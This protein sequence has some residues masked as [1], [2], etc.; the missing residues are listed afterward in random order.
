MRQDLATVVSGTGQIKPKTYVN[1]GA[2]RHGPHHPPLC[3]GGRPGEE[4]PTRCHDRKRGQQAA[5]VAGQEAAI[6][7]PRRT[8]PPTSL[9]KKPP[10][11]MWNTLRPTWSKRSSIGI[12]RRASLQGRHHGQAGLR[13][14]EGRL[15]HRCGF[16]GSGCRR[17]EPGQGQ[18]RLRARP[19]AERRWPRCEP[20]RTRSN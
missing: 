9:R 15:R 13:R 10:K 12:V 20:I 6:P 4:G 8:S 2:N 16:V 14:Q 19:P 17:P 18:D 3:E 5:N 1:L 11:P 7:R